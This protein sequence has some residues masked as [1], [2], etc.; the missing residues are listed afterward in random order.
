MWRKEAREREQKS[1]SSSSSS[2]SVCAI[3]PFR[4]RSVALCPFGS[5]SNSSF[6]SFEAKLGPV[7]EKRESRTRSRSSAPGR[8]NWLQR[9]RCSALHWEICLQQRLTVGLFSIY[10][11]EVV[12]QSENVSPTDEGKIYVPPSEIVKYLLLVPWKFSLASFWEVKFPLKNAKY[13]LF[14]H[15]YNGIFRIFF[16]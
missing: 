8:N 10:A 9:E 5:F 15:T 2:F 4:P 11:S 7:S 14:A 6:L 13:A 3:S 16:P 12:S 1:L